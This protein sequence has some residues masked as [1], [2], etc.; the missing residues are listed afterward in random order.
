[1]DE[2]RR[3][4]LAIDTDRLAAEL[5]VP[6]I[7]SVARSGEGMAA[8]KLPSGTSVTDILSALPF[9]TLRRRHRSI[10]GCYYGGIG[11]A[12]FAVFS[13]WLA[14]R[15]LERDNSLLHAFWTK[16]K[17]K[18]QLPPLFLPGHKEG[19][20]MA[21]LNPN[22]AVLAASHSCCRP[23]NAIARSAGS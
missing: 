21:R 18:R 14:L 7:P 9:C 22:Q 10:P 17:N 23:A 1:M 19:G 4:G 8:L 13:R 3:Q 2:A 15:I 5:G 20:S 11:T 16:N 6:C 12:G